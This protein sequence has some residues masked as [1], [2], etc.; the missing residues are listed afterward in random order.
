MG[1]LVSGLTATVTHEVTQED[2]ASAGGSGDLDVLGTPRLLAL[3][4]AA[5]CAAIAAQ[6]AT[7]ESS[8]G[9]QVQ[10]DHS[11]PSPVGARLKVT[12]TL[13]HVDG[14]L[15]RFDVAAEHADGA[16]VANGEITRVVV[17]RERFARQL[18]A[19]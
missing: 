3:A 6:L 2:T 16:A 4:E 17:D 11:T 9:T 18:S 13:V 10:L 15:L 7:T 1:D 12:A 19:T 5:T 8:V 14:R